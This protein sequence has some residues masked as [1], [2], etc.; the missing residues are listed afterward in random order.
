MVTMFV[1]HFGEL[2]KQDI[3]NEWS[4]D[5]MCGIGGMLGQP[6]RTVLSRMNRLMDHR[7][8]DGNGIFQMISVV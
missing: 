8:P 5:T 2:A 7:G 3:L 4:S 1:Y 6:D